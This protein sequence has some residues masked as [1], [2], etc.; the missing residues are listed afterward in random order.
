MVFLKW[1]CGL[2]G[3]ILGLFQVC[4]RV[5]LKRFKGFCMVI[6]TGGRGCY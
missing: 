4:C 2:F 1:F 5:I 6:V 3:L